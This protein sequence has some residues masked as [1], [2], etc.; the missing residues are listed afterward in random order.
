MTSPT[1]PAAWAS[2]QGHYAGAVSRLAAYAIDL[3]VSSGLFTLALAAIT[4]VVNLL[5]GHHVAWN[6]GSIIVAVVYAAWE[7]LYFAYSWAAGGKTFGMAILG[8]E[9]VRA[10]GTDLDPWR[11]VI[12]TLALPLSFLL[13]GLG[14]AGILLQR[15]HR[16][17]HDLIAGTAVVYAWDA[18]A[19]RIRFLARQARVPR[20][21]PGGQHPASSTERS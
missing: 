8:I 11:A 17:L 13:F 1:P 10:D 19:A 20:A 12:R 15:E 18:R 5:T 7:F 21:V 14:F 6:K 16:A 3:A 4:Y 9:V 2:L